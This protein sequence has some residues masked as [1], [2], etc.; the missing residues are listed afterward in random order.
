MRSLPFVVIALAAPTAFITNVSAHEHEAEHRLEELVSYFADGAVIGEPSIVDC[1]LNDGT[2]TSCFAITV[3]GEPESHESGPWCPTNISQSG[4]DAGGIWLENDQ[5]Y[6]VD[7]PFIERLT[8]LYDDEE[9]QLFNP[10][11][12]EIRVT[13]TLEGCQAAARPNV[14]PE[15]NQY[16]VQCQISD[17]SRPSTKT[18]VFPV[19]PVAAD[20]P[21]PSTDNLGVGIAI[22][23]ARIDGPAPRDAILAA[24]T[25]APF[26]DCGGHV[27][28]GVGYHYHAITDCATSVESTTE[29]HAQIIGIALDGYMIHTRFD[30][31]GTEPSDLDECR[32]HTSDGL[33]Y[34]YHANDPAANA[35]LP[36]HTAATGCM[37]TGED[38]QCDATTVINH[39]G[40]GRDH[41]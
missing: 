30:E 14:D 9:F 8:A 12:G 16:C 15:W 39:R 3:T 20:T 24:H 37:L 25:L 5:V 4:A 21:T 18:Y 40:P 2:E 1:K 23:G 31:D 29:G 34:H 17:M 36:C 35:I 32:G 28:L 26:D 19:T 27:N 22:S 41:D 10:E 33:G 7:G 11:T 6:E 38:T 13:D